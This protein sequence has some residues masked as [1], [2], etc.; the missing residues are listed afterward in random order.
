MELEWEQK[1]EHL[2][3]FMQKLKNSG[4]DECFRLEVLKSS[5]NGY[6]KIVEDAKNGLKPIYRSKEWKEKNNWTSKKKYKKENW[7]KGKQEIE[8]KSII[9]VPRIFFKST[10][11]FPHH[12]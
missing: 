8:N 6:E 5:I 11:S 3:K 7:W 12:Y 10:V 4:Y 1:A 9:F 2:N